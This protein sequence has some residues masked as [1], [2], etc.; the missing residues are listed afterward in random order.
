[1]GIKMKKNYIW[2]GFLYL[3]AGLIFAI[4]SIKIDGKMSSLLA[5]FSG[6]GIGAGIMMIGKYLYW[7]HPVRLEQYKTRLE[8]EDIELKDERNEMY[9]DKAGRHAYKIGLII[10]SISI[11][12]F[13]IL[14]A[15]DVYSS[16]VIILYLLFLLIFLYAFGIFS[17]RK[18]KKDK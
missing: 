4:V 7:S 6:G 2:Y 13:S 8:E 17:Y 15:L 3:L 12:I 1:M 5:G 14:N 9:R 11:V 18:L 10:I 16:T